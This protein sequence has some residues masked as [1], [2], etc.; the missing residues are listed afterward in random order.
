MLNVLLVIKKCFIL[1]ICFA[2][3]VLL[4]FSKSII[5]VENNLCRK[6]IVVVCMIGSYLN[7]R[8]CGSY[9]FINNEY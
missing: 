9:V 2:F 3:D 7:I 5:I 4:D 1:F 8:V 6:S